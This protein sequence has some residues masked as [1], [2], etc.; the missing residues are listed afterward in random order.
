MTRTIGL[1]VVLTALVLCG[2]SKVDSDWKAAVA[3]NSI[4]AYEAHLASFPDTPHA[5]EAR[6]AITEL[7]WQAA[8]SA[9]TV[10]ALEQFI[11]SHPEAPQLDAAKSKLAERR[12]A[13][14][15]ADLDDVGEKLRAFLEGDESNNVI[16]TIGSMKF[17]PRARAPQSNVVVHGGSQMMAVIGGAVRVIYVAGNDNTIASVEDY[18]FAI[19][20]PIEMTNGNR[21]T[22]QEG[23]WVA[24]Q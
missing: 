18:E 6:T 12:A 22:W 1:V 14:Q 24:G 13:V 23:G 10:D 9:N 17:V 5:A 21:Y 2:C 8:D 15:Q 7:E 3:E 4:A 11:A 19:G 16:A 20:A